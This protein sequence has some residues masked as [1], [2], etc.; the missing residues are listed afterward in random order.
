[1]E[2]NGVPRAGLQPQQAISNS[3][4]TSATYIAALEA[5]PALPKR[6]FELVCVQSGRRRH[7]RYGRR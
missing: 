3:T 2:E 6:G 4:S 5:V 1:M 7:D